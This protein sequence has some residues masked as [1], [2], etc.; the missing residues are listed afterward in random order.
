VGRRDHH[1]RLLERVVASNAR[2]PDRLRRSFLLV[3]CDGKV[4]SSLNRHSAIGSDSSCATSQAAGLRSIYR[5]SWLRP[6]AYVR[7]AGRI[8]R[9][10]T[11]LRRTGPQVRWMP[12]LVSMSQHLFGLSARAA[13]SAADNGIVYFILSQSLIGLTLIWFAVCLLA[14]DRTL[15]LTRLLCMR[16]GFFIPLNLL[17]SLLVLF[18]QDCGADLVLLRV[19]RHAGSRNRARA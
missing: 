4:G 8:E 2:L 5:Q 14:P 18:D 13:E 10:T 7:L 19:S 16:L 9:L 15:P 12:S 17:I 6:A 11:T 3:S 1:P